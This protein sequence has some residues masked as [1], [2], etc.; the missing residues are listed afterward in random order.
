MPRQMPAFAA[1]LRQQVLASVELAQSGDAVIS[2]ERWTLTRVE[3][4]YELAYLRMFLEWE[5]FLEKTFLRY[6]CGYQSSQGSCTPVPGS[7]H[8]E[9]LADA[10]AALFGTRDYVLW[11]RPDVIIARAQ[12]FW[13]GSFYEQVIASFQA[14][15]E[16]LANVRHRIVHAQEDAATKFEAATMAI[17]GRRY[18]GARPGRFLRDWNRSVSPNQ[19]WLENL[20]TELFQI[21]RQIG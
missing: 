6:L 11:H 13:V 18:R 19:R 10:E 16:I 3:L 12:R 8:F 14:R 1:R 20:G 7:R 2:H 4:L 21:A 5:Q 17:C 9:T 15:L